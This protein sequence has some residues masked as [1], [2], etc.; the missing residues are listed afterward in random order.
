[1]IGGNAR[2]IVP[3]EFAERFIAEP[4]PA[5]EDSVHHRQPGGT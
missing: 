2:Q 5:T 3:E 1:M 4:L